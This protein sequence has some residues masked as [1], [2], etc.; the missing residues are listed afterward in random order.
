MDLAWLCG[1][2]ILS[3]VGSLMYSSFN[4]GWGGVGAALTEDASPL[5]ITGELSS[6][7]LI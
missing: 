1:L 4:A 7:K 5:N 2:C 3:V 6:V